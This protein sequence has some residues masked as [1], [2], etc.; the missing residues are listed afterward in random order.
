MKEVCFRKEQLKHS[1]FPRFISS[2]N[3]TKAKTAGRQ[4]MRSKTNA[5][6][7]QALMLPRGKTIEGKLIK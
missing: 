4:I 1:I 6:V 2:G 5:N 7:N 3:C